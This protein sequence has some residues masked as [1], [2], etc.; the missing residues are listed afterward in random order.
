MCL[1]LMLG[2]FVKNIIIVLCTFV[3]ISLIC[4]QQVLDIHLETILHEIICE[5]TTVL[6]SSVHHSP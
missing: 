6:V 4:H 3:L 2:P 1:L 5:W